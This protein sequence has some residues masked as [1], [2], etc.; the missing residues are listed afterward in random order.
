MSRMPIVAGTFYEASPAAC[1]SAVAGLL[2]QARP[3]D[4][5]PAGCVGG[6]VP[7][8]GWVCSGAVAALTLK[9]VTRDWAGQTMVLLGA[10]H[11]RAGA[12]G[13]LYSQGKWR[14]PLGDVEIDAD[15]GQ[16]ISAACADVDDDPAPHAREH[17]L[18]VQ[19]PLIQVLCP[20]ARIVPLMVP[21][22]PKAA[23][24]GRQVGALLAQRDRTVLVLGSTDLTHY[25]P[26]YGITPAGVGHAGIEWATKNDRKLLDLIES[27]AAEE[28]VAHTTRY[29]SACGGGAIAAT[30]AACRELG[31][32]TGTVLCH[33]NSNETLRAHLGA[34]DDN[35]VGYASVVFS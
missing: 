27:M 14:S 19:L 13:M 1:R 3:P 23:D 20:G 11:A 32:T 25:G 10:V 15:L 7:H 30:I 5:V 8:A 9:A 21:P 28:I 6:L 26:R 34:D 12:S 4:S 18:E 29:H 31:A 22:S 17:S 24:I 35:A 16:T 33:T 2:D